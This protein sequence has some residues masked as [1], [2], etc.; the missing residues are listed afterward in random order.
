MA[1]LPFQIVDLIVIFGE[2]WKRKFDKLGIAG[3]ISGLSDEQQRFLQ[4]GGTGFILGDGNLYYRPEQV[5]ETYYM[6]AL[7]KNIFISMD[8]QYIVN[9]GYNNER[10]N[11]GVWA[12]RSHIEL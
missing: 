7:T 1:C 9:V 12:L 5:V 6:F 4:R 10:G 11:V 2:N 3:V 8:Y